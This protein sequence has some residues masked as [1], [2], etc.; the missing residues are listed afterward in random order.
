[1][2]TLWLYVEAGA[3]L[4]VLGFLLAMALFASPRKGAKRMVLIRWTA[5]PGE[6]WPAVLIEC[7][8]GGPVGWLL[9]RFARKPDARLMVTREH[10]SLEKAGVHGG[11]PM[12]PVKDI[13]GTNCR[14]L[15]KKSYYA[16]AGAAALVVFIYARAGRLTFEIVAGAVIVAAAAC[17]LSW[18]SRAVEIEIKAPGTVMTLAVVSPVFRSRLTLEDAKYVCERINEL[19]HLQKGAHMKVVHRTFEPKGGSSNVRRE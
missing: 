18:L 5:E 14:Q 9:A 12:I 13:K 11:M 6:L 7:R 8:R 4:L 1:M 16:A 10:A 3:A 15:Q 17:L 19:A 2:V